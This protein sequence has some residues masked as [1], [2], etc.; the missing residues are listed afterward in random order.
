MGFFSKLFSSLFGGGGKKQEEANDPNVQALE[1]YFKEKLPANYVNSPKYAVSVTQ[2][3][4]GYAAVIT[5]DMGSD[6]SDYTG[7]GKDDFEICQSWN[8]ATSLTSFSKIRL[9]PSGPPLLWTSGLGTKSRWTG[10]GP[11]QSKEKNE[12]FRNVLFGSFST[13]WT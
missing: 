7:F 4:R 11:R 9:C 2:D 3:G 6:G 12:A 1:R 10:A 8:P 13:P 5:L